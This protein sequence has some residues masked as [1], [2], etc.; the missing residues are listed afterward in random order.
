MNR[1]CAVAVFTALAFIA[2]TS[3]SLACGTCG[4]GLNSDWI[5][6][7]FTFKPGFHMDLRFDYFNQDQ[8][9]TGLGTVDKGSI[10]FPSDREIQLV[11]INRNYNLDFGY[12]PN[13]EWGFD[14]LVPAYDRTHSTIAEE[15]SAP[16]YSRSAGI[17]DVRIL[18]RYQGF[19]QDRSFGL[20]FGVKLPTGRIDDTFSSG[21]QAGNTVD[22]GLQLGT[23]T[24]DLLVGVYKSGVM[25]TNWGYFAQANVQ[26]P[27]DSKD[28]FKPG[29]ALNVN[30]GIRYTGYCSVTPQLQLNVRAEK[31]ETGANADTANSG[32]TLAYLSPGV[33]VE[34]ARKANL[35][36]FIQVPVYQR[37]TGYQLEPRYLL[38]V[39][40]HV[41]F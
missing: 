22:R 19:A 23:G 33:T 12:N 27:L 4:C 13:A 11:T 9:R 5:S 31:P 30:A 15:D 2:I 34:L 16:S 17:G 8:L 20:Q 21:P 14:V 41:K 40:I 39:G 29:N 32:A 36:V 6:Q 35:F 38:S 1:Q 18:A 28:E 10:T 24:T 7:G 37:V 25:A 26:L 3:A